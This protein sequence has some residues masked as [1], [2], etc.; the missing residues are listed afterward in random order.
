[1]SYQ[2]QNTIPIPIIFTLD[3]DNE[4]IKQLVNKKN[5]LFFSNIK[6]H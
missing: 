3:I 6:A 2:F 4:I 5:N 1:M